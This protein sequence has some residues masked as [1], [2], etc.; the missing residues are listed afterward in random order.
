MST[1][2]AGLAG[3]MLSWCLAATGCGSGAAGGVAPDGERSGAASPAPQAAAPAAAGVGPQ[4]W[5]RVRL[6]D[7]QLFGQDTTFVSM[8]I[9]ADW[10]WQ[11]AVDIA[12]QEFAGCP[13]NALS[14]HGE[15]VSADGRL[16]VTLLPAH[17]T[18]CRCTRMARSRLCRPRATRIAT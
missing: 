15:A 10:R 13:E 2:R 18:S 1:S 7:Q 8:L 14:P 9:P 12:P 16:A 4:R 17:T 5:K 11:A 6:A 3:L